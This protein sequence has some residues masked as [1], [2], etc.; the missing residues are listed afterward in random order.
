MRRLI[1][2]CAGIDVG[3]GLLVVCV[4][5]VDGKG[6]LDQQVRSLGA[7]ARYAGDRRCHCRRRTCH[8]RFAADL[9]KRPTQAGAIVVTV[10]A[11]PRYLS[12]P[13]SM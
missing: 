12:A 6:R 9:T 7:T 1:G 10:P 11:E 13:F 8:P 2:R 5:V 4:R 3:H